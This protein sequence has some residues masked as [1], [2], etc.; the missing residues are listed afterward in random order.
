M[1]LPPPCPASQPDRVAAS[2]GPI[3]VI[4]CRLPLFTLL[5]VPATSSTPVG[6]SIRIGAKLTSA[7]RSDTIGVTRKPV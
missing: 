1:A 3:F 4:S 6:V 2:A 5:I 7:I